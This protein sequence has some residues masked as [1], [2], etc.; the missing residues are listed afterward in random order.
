MKW[1]RLVVVNLAQNTADTLWR[2]IWKLITYFCLKTVNI[3]PAFGS[4]TVN[5]ALIDFAIHRHFDN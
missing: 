1:N 5:N 3:T 2:N 4:Q